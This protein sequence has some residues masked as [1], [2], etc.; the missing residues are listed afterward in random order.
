MFF[1]ACAL[2]VNPSRPHSAVAASHYDKLARIL[3]R[4]G[5]IFLRRLVLD[6]ITGVTDEFQELLP[7]MIFVTRSWVVYKSDFCF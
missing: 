5:E 1:F 2:V 7:R 3:E 4:R 6:F